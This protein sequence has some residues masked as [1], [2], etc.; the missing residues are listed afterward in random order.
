MKYRLLKI[1]TKDDVIVPSVAREYDSIEDAK[2]KEMDDE[3]VDSITLEDEDGYRH[4][5]IRTREEAS[6]ERA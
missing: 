5:V 6:N 4:S 1:N 3:E 2:R